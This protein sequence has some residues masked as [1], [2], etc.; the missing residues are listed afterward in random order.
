MKNQ[1]DAQARWRTLYKGTTAYND[2]QMVVELVG[3]VR[4][5]QLMHQYA[6]E[7][8]F[9]LRNRDTATSF[10]WQ[11]DRQMRWYKGFESTVPAPART[12]LISLLGFSYL[13]GWLRPKNIT[14]VEAT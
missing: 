12:H 11:M 14:P 2:I 8:E 6:R 9:C 7:H 4:W 13:T 1:V 10:V 5:S 3:E